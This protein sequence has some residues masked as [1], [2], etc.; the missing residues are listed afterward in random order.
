MMGEAQ[1]LDTVSHNP[2]FSIQSGMNRKGIGSRS[3]SYFKCKRIGLWFE[4][5]LG[6]IVENIN[7]LSK[8]RE[9]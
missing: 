4:T 8:K 2:S 3:S 1:Y 7:F 6:R 5:S 9:I